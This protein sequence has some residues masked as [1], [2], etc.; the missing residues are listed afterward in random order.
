MESNNDMSAQAPIIPRTIQNSRYSLLQTPNWQESGS[1]SSHLEFLWHQTA[2]LWN[3]LKFWNFLRPRYGVEV[4]IVGILNLKS[5]PANWLSTKMEGSLQ[6]FCTSA[7]TKESPCTQHA[8]LLGRLTLFQVTSE[9]N[10]SILWGKT[11]TL[12]L[13]VAQNRKESK[14]PFI[15]T[16]FGANTH[17]SRDC[18]SWCSPLDPQRDRM[19]SQ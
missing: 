11:T 8:E 4:S 19:H 7:Q 9:L 12:K 5:T 16:C 17:S 3:A 10:S 13:W 6:L 18:C 1:F 14:L 2:F 15:P